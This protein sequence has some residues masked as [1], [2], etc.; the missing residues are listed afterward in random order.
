MNREIIPTYIRCMP[1]DELEDEIVRLKR[2]RETLR[3]YGVFVNGEQA[4]ANAIV[5][6]HDHDRFLDIRTCS[7]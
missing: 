4:I 2:E 5:E 6:I 3:S 7:K 1:R